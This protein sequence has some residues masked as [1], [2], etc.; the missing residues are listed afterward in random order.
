VLRGLKIPPTLSLK[1]CGFCHGEGCR[2]ARE[3]IAVVLA[4]GHAL[5]A[6]EALSRPDALSADNTFADGSFRYPEP[7]G[8]LLDGYSVAVH[9]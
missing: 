8:S 7:V 6:Q 1:V 9:V 4:I 3:E 5:I 2:K